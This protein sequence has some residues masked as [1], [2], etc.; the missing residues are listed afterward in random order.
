MLSDI[1]RK[2]L[3]IIGNYSAGRRRLPTIHEIEI[4]AGRDRRGVMEVL[5]VLAAEGYI[6]WDEEE[7]ESMVLLEAWERKPVRS[8]PAFNPDR[9]MD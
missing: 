5:A 3:R 2:V 9:F 6:L 4:K 7:P 1:E 8:D